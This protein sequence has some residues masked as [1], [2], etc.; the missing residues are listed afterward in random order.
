LRDGAT[1]EA[2]QSIGELD[3]DELAAVV[4]PSGY[5]RD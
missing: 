4:P 1:D 3:L 2:L 5:G